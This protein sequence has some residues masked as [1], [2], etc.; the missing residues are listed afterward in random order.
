MSFEN[1]KTVL[2][3]L[4]NNGFEAYFVGGC[5]RD[6]LLQAPVGDID[7]T[8]NAKPEQVVTLFKKTI[9]T[10]MQHGTVTVMLFGESFEVT[11]YR[12]E[13]EYID[14]RR[15][16]S[17]EWTD[18]LELDLARRDF[19]MNAIAMNRH[20]EIVDPYGGAQHIK[21][22]RIVT[23]GGA[24]HRF[25]ED[26]LRM[27]RALRFQSQLGFSLD[28]NVML[29]IAEN[30]ALLENISIERMTV[31]WHK[32]LA[33][34]NRNT[35]LRSVV[36][37]EVYQHFPG[38]ENMKMEIL[39]LAETENK[40]LQSEEAWVYLFHKENLECL[41]TKLR[42]WKLSN[43][44][45]RKILQCVEGIQS[46]QQWNDWALYS[47]GF[48]NAMTIHAVLR[49][50]GQSAWSEEEL[51]QRFANLPIKNKSEINI[52]GHVL[53]TTLQRSPGPWLKEM[54]Q[55]IERRIVTKQLEN[56]QSNIV[57]WCQNENN[58]S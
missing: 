28:E 1:G 20:G 38:Y 27:L 36:A 48:E 49:L 46:V 43:N 41:Q 58:Q 53:T 40:V 4:E 29:A 14:F 32:L 2:E 3:I 34:K 25:R 50:I 42:A 17:V 37:T 45:Q 23:V 16:D 35:A 57:R 47:Y 24:A 19:T 22:Q 10:G 6:T 18:S 30:K 51:T 26:G 21:E 31:E 39:K 52:N 12:T 7:I 44:T 9:P 33:G 8:T 55:Q 54:L 13:G 56:V 11:T 5:V 15:P